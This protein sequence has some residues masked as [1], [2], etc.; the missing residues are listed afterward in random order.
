ML[1]S[2]ELVNWLSR[3]GNHDFTTCEWNVLFSRNGDVGM[4]ES[5]S[6]SRQGRSQD[7]IS[8]EAKGRTGGLGAEPPAGSRSR[9]PCQGRSPSEA[10]SLSV[11]RY[12]KEMENLL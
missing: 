10:E 8:T 6:S 12:P 2:I 9:A 4:H 11:V 1:R 3:D 5:C 7:F